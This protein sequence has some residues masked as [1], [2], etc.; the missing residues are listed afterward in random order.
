MD[1]TAD[2]DVTE[3]LAG[4]EQDLWA[5][6]RVSSA[7]A[8]QESVIAA[9]RYVGRSGHLAAERALAE[10]PEVSAVQGLQAASRL[11]E[12]LT[13]RRWADIQRAREQGASWSQIG[14]ALGMSKQGAQDWYARKIADQ[15]RYVG[16][17]H[18][19]DRARAALG[20]HS[21]RITDPTV[22]D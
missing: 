16:S 20:E 7:R 22:E 5:V 2:F 21:P 8:R 11:A 18:D 1:M 4:D 10:L 3:A 14:E 13:A 9:A 15:E 6:H 17:Y 12:L 19:A